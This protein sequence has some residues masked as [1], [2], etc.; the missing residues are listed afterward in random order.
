MALVL[1]SL[2]AGLHTDDRIHAARVKLQGGL[3]KGCFDM[4]T[5]ADGTAAFTRGMR[6]L[7][8]FPWWTPPDYRLAFFRPLSS[9]SHCVD[10]RF[11]A[12][13]PW[14]MHAESVLAYGAAILAVAAALR[15]TAAAPWLAGLG[16]W[17]WAVDDAHGVA[18]GWVASRNLVLAALF[19]AL[20]LRDHARGAAGARGATWRAP[21]WLALALLSAEAGVSA[22]G[23]LV[24]HAIVLEAGP[25]TRRALR[26]LP[27]IAVIVAWR[28]AY[29]ALGF[30][31]RGSSAYVDP[32]ASPLAFA[33]TA[34]ERL[35][36]LLG[37][38]L[39]PPETLTTARLPAS[40]S[41]SIAIG[42]EAA[43]VALVLAAVVAV[44]RRRPAMRFFALATL[45]ATLP[46]CT[47]PPSDRVLTVPGIAA[48]GLVAELLGA[49]VDAGAS[50][51]GRAVGA[52]LAAV[53]VLLAPVLLPWRSLE[54]ARFSAPFDPMGPRLF[55]DAGPGDLVVVVRSDDVFGCTQ[56]IAAAYGAD[57]SHGAFGR[58]LSGGRSPA[59]VGRPDAFTLSIRPEAGFLEVPR[60][61]LQWSG[62]P[63]HRLD[64]IELTGTVVTILDVDDRGEPRE[65][66]FRFELPLED[67]HVHFVVERH[68][69]V[70]RF[71]L[72]EVGTQVELPGG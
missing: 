49:A 3:G 37:W 32:L 64:T 47:A 16:A 13:S 10:H 58:C 35:P 53:H 22:W 38:Q 39:G 12:A 57:A 63:L 42:L 1:P 65:A 11:F 70:E 18:V 45:L 46:C 71:A 23:L 48:A 50:S 41:P 33:R 40:W 67:P 17:L 52:A 6:D 28:A 34:A 62:A 14:V 69:R 5:F 29:V 55:A 60:H 44:A 31:Q 43:I 24:A 56:A 54:F 26:Q 20:A 25:W 51:L 2:A 7:G 21:A 61:R 36:M 72:P 4:F 19:A 68:G 59:L 30:G 66:S 15:R 9:L 27:Y 8:I